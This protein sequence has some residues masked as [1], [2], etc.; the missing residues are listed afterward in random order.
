ML[1][2]YIVLGVFALRR[3]RTR[4]AFLLAALAVYL[5]IISVAALTGRSASSSPRCID[6]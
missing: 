1:P 2:V 4:A 3:G 5:F 6:A